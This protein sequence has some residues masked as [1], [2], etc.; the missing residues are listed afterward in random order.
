V[1]K[2][3]SGRGIIKVLLVALIFATWA[4]AGIGYASA[5]E[6]HVYP[7]Q[8]IQT[9]INNAD[10]DD[11]IY[12]H[13]GTY[14]EHVN[15]NKRVTLIGVDM[16]VI[17]AVNPGGVTTEVI[18]LSADGITL[19]NFTVISANSYA[20]KVISSHNIITGNTVYQNRV[21]EMIYQGIYFD[22][23]NSNI[24]TNNTIY[25]NSGVVLSSSN[26]N[27]IIGNT[28]CNSAHGFELHGSNGNTLSNNTVF[29]SSSRG[30]L[31][32]GN[33]NTVIGNNV[34][35]SRHDNGIL[36]GGKNNIV[37]GNTVSNNFDYGI[38]ISHASTNTLIG[39]IISNNTHDGIYLYYSSNNHLTGNIFIA[40]GLSLSD[41]YSYNNTV[42]NNTVNGKPLVY[43][44]SV[45]D[46]IVNDAGQVI[47][48]R[49]AHIRIED[50]NVSHT[51]IGIQLL[52]TE[53]CQIVHCIFTN[54]SCGI[55]LYNS[56]SN[57]ITSNTFSNNGAGI[58]AIKNLPYAFTGNNIFTDNIFSNN[59]Y[60]V[61][62]YGS[63]D[64]TFTSNTFS[65]NNKGIHF[66]ESSCNTITGNII[67]NNSD[68]INLD[69]SIYST[70]GNNNVIDNIVSNNTIGIHL[71]DSRGNTVSGNTVFNNS[72]GISLED[73]TISNIIT[74]NT[75]CNNRAFGIII[76]FYS[77]DNLIYNNYFNNVNNSYDDNNNIWNIA[78]SS[79][80]NIVG[81]PFLG[82]NYWSD[83]TG[84]D[85]NGDRLGDT[86]I[87]YN[88]S[89]RIMNGGDWRPLVIVNL[90][91][92]AIIDSITPNPAKQGKETVS[93]V[94]HG[95]DS[96]GSVVAY[97]WT[98]SI[99]GFL[100]TSSAFTK[101]ASELLVGTH[102]IYF[103]VQ[104]DY[105]A[106]SSPA[107]EI[108]T[109]TTNQPP[110]A[111]F[112]YSPMN[113]GIN[114][115]VTFNDS[116]S[117]DPDGSIVSYNW[118]F[119]DVNS[120]NTTVSTITHSYAS[121]GEYTV[122]LTVTDDE[123]ATNKTSRVIKVFP[124]V[125]YFDTE[126]GTYPSI[127]GTHNGTITMTHTVNVSKIYIYPCVGTGGHIEYAKIWNNSRE[128]AEAHWNGYIDDWHNPPFDKNFT[129][130]AG[131]T[132]NYSI[133]TG[134]YPQIHHK[135]ELLTAKGWITCEEFVDING[136]RHAGWI[137]AIK[138]Y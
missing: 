22:N 132:Y 44:E 41:I 13:A 42:E 119:G 45:S 75:I 69:H 70:F 92:T 115:I 61:Y 131:E 108:L 71:E 113:P 117:Y 114:E 93:F 1:L 4:V 86:L 51:G 7:G 85:T 52:D 33:N 88:S 125:P 106:W 126:P 133:R 135:H 137:P 111:S 34:S 12:V 25:N 67:S 39:N 57:S 101:P 77:Y 40:N 121:V 109:I 120:T 84:N 53:D 24:I 36:I 30:I 107:T 122:N 32:G 54:N 105:G 26:S 11:T 82:G 99:D 79:G 63:S 58:R 56:S 94:G 102:T 38:F 49:C 81:G 80:T 73:T 129:L 31:L 66:W 21:G 59:R 65:N 15:V 96:D 136:K 110:V 87:P 116:T 134:S 90:P 50:V 9:A 127:P 35:N 2:T 123:G 46:Q 95:N 37:S 130:V 62:L 72:V 104:D 19:E 27:I 17:T 10:V 14:N 68:G 16:P 47:L 91:P 98:S 48:V 103:T 64:N 100:N 74:G 28:V 138:L 18:T 3:N 78:K 83:Y 76:V 118:S 6:R 112:S 20:I 128:G 97:N 23:S 124:D 55:E 8:S 60:G 43:L 89:G 29:S 5:A